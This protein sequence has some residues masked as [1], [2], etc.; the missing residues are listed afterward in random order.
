M[1]WYAV[2]LGNYKIGIGR[3]VLNF[4]LC[5]FFGG[6]VTKEVSMPHS[7]CVL[8]TISL[9]EYRDVVRTTLKG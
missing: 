7:S 1:N 2:C 9:F 5:P 3:F 8:Y 4:S 6:P